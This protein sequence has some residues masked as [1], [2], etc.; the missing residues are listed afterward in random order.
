MLI[1]IPSTGVPGFAILTVT[2]DNPTVLLETSVK[3]PVVMFFEAIICSAGGGGVSVP[4]IGST[5]G[6]SHEQAN[7]NRTKAKI[8]F[9][10]IF[11]LLT[12]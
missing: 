3:V 5:D 2:P 9:F 1:S 12:C 10:F 4:D 7:P 11:V 6:L 8:I